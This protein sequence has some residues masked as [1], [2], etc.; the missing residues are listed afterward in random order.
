MDCFGVA[1]VVVATAQY[2][3]ND[4]IHLALSEDHAWVVFG[5][6]KEETAEVTWHGK[7][8]E[9]KRGSPINQD[10]KV[11]FMQDWLYLAGNEVKCDRSMEVAAIVS[12]LNP[13]INSKTDSKTVGQLQQ[14]NFKPCLPYLIVFLA[15]EPEKHAII[16]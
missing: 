12:A 13:G 9:A 6:I 5:D 15:D 10:C 8:N 14:V 7:G 3:G 4:S 1:F 2:L 11:D 16:I